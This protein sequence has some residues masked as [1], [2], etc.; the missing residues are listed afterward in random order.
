MDRGERLLL[1][2]LGVALTAG[3]IWFLTMALPAW[4]SELLAAAA[5]LGAGLWLVRAGWVR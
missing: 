2:A 1:L 5:L 4:A 3:G